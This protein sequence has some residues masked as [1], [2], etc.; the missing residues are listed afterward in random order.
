MFNSLHNSRH[1]FRL[2]LLTMT[3][4]DTSGPLRII[5][6]GKQVFV[7]GEGGE[8]EMFN[9]RTASEFIEQMKN[10]TWAGWKP[11]DQ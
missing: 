2:I 10:R 5:T 8:W 11:K 9:H 1:Y 7:I 3:D 4:I 6:Q